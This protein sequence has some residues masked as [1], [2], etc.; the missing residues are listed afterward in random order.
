MVKPYD[1]GDAVE[2][3]AIFVDSNGV[4]QDPTTVSITYRAEAIGISTTR[5]YGSGAYV[6]RLSQGKYQFTYNSAQESAGKVFYDFYGTGQYAGA[7]SGEFYVRPSK[8]R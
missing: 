2:I 7:I 4:R 5:T 6:T 1:Y 8:V 3:I